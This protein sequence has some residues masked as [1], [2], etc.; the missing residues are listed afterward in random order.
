MKNSAQYVVYSDGA[1]SPTNPGPAGWGAVV[2]DPSNSITRFYGFLGHGTNQIAEV[3]AA[4]NG[5]RQTPVGCHVELVSDSQYVLKGVSE[6]R[7]GWERRGWKNAA[8][9]PVANQ[10]LFKALFKLVDERVVT[11]RWVKGHNGD[12]FNEQADTLANHGLLVPEIGTVVKYA[13]AAS[14]T[15]AEPTPRKPSHAVGT[16]VKLRS[17]GETGMILS[18]WYDVNIEQ[19]YVVFFEWTAV[20]KPDVKPF[21]LRYNISDLVTI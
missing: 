3:A 12:K 5:L 14:A 17:T 19:A 2:I 15:P 18:S 1:C 7:K 8:G 4:V 9:Q 13:R 11:T 6:W 10:D 20:G 21:V 16:H